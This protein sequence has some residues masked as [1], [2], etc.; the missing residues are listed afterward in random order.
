MIQYSAKKSPISVLLLIKYILFKLLH[1]KNF[2]FNSIAR[3]KDAA[4]N[5][6]FAKFTKD[7]IQ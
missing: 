2:Y 4:K 5:L 3:L 6:K 7:L 1:I